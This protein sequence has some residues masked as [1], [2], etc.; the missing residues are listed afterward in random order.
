MKR[1]PFYDL[2]ITDDFW[3][4]R[5]KTVMETTIGEVYDRFNETGR[6]HTM[7]CADQEPLPH[8]FWG[9]DTVKW[10]EAAAYALQFKE[11][12]ALRKKLFDLVESIEQGTKAD[13][14]Y[15]SHYNHPKCENPRFTERKNHELYS[16]GHMIEAAVAIRQILEDDRLLKICERNVDLVDRIF[17]VEDA[18]NFATPGHQE[19][20][21]ALVR[22]Y[23]TTGDE[24]YLKL[25]E[26]FVRERGRNAKDF[27]EIETYNQISKTHAAY[28]PNGEYTQTHVPIEEQEEAVGHA[29]RAVYYYCAVADLA[30]ELGD[31]ELKKAAIRLFDN[32]YEK[33]MYITGG[34]GASRAGERFSANYHLPN[35]EAYAETC[36]AL[37]LALFARRLSAMEAD[38]RYGDA[39]ER[40]L[41]NGMLSGMSLEGDSFFY[42][43]PLEI[44]L[45]RRNMLGFSEGVSVRQ[46]Y[47][48][49]SC[50][51][52][53]IA[54][55]IL[56][57]GDF[58]YTYNDDTLFVHQ[59]FANQGNIDGTAI[60][61]ESSYLADGKV[62][63]AYAGNKKLALRK[64]AWCQ[65][66]V[67]DAPYREEKGYLYFDQSDVELQFVIEPTFWQSADAV[68]ENAG[69]VALQRGPIIYCMEGKDQIA[70]LYRLRV[71]ADQVV[72]TA[73]ETYAGLPVLYAQGVAF[74]EQTALYAPYQA[75]TETPCKIR[76][77]PFYSF[78]NRGE[79]NMQ[80]WVLKK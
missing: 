62:K 11:D 30:K 47:F 9:S 21:L 60:A 1:V 37:G 32:I 22:M 75:P 44:D 61:M 65:K 63:I 49:C 14:Y 39:V 29:V 55:L 69:R 56:S 28:D 35:R 73:N 68:H 58:L 25:S 17:R 71:C 26:F 45:E 80:V 67:C 70:P 5:Q 41:Y 79:D 24:K 43:N 77:I 57:V 16:L 54:R 59:Y 72:E 10:M 33:K 31:E 2:K 40:A 52:P 8:I 13:G 18:A 53:N 74:G 4:E 64:P 3:A 27:A 7:N 15:N 48:S 38:G 42:E 34:I 76:F 51:P 12:P 36:A 20:E 66:V 46:K 23:E 50:C 6:I 19:I 78:A